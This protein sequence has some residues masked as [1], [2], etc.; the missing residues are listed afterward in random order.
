MFLEYQLYFSA[1]KKSINY[2]DSDKTTYKK[3]KYVNNLVFVR[4]PNSLRV[5]KSRE[6]NRCFDR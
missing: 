6:W 3:S 4:S 5:I 2:R 1:K